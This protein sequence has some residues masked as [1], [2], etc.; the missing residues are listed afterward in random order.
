M[1][2]KRRKQPVPSY[3]EAVAQWRLDLRTEV[4]R[5]SALP[6]SVFATCDPM[7]E[8]LLAETAESMLALLQEP[9]PQAAIT[10]P[11]GADK[12]L[13]TVT[14]AELRELPER[15]AEGGPTDVHLDAGLTG[16]YLAVLT[17]ACGSGHEAAAHGASIL[18]R[19]DFGIH[20]NDAGLDDTA[21]LQQLLDKV[22]A[23][24]GAAAPHLA[25]LCQRLS[26]AVTAHKTAAADHG[27]TE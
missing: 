8:S 6:S 7:I 11:E 4:K 19:R 25:E 23:G 16:E 27:D 9:S 2:Q 15:I 17:D 12:R 5:A 1:S 13:E 18:L 20:G 10:P 14:L 3:P 22:I 24:D 21:A 26:A